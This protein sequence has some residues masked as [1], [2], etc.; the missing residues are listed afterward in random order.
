MTIK[1]SSKR[2]TIKGSS[3][4]P[5]KT[6]FPLLVFI[7]LFVVLVLAVKGGEILTG[8]NKT[9]NGNLSG[10]GSLTVPGD[11]AYAITADAS[12]NIYVG[13][14]GAGLTNNSIGGL[15]DWWL[16]K[17]YRNGTEDLTN[18]NKI[19][20]GWFNDSA[21]GQYLYGLDTDSSGNIYLIGSI[22]DYNASYVWLVNR[23]NSSGS[24]NRTWDIRS[25]YFSFGRDIAVDSNNNV[26]A[27]GATGTYTQHIEKY[28]TNAVKTW[29][30]NASCPSPLN[31]P[32]DLNAIAIDSTN[33]IFAAGYCGGKVSVDFFWDIQKFSNAGVQ[34][35]SWNVS[36]DPEDV[37]CES[38]FTNQC[39]SAVV[40]DLAIDSAGN[41][42]AVGYGQA[43][44]NATANYTNG[45]LGSSDDWLVR[46]YNTAG[47]L[48]WSRNFSSTLQPDSDIIYTVSID[49]SNNIYLAG[50]WN[51]SYWHVKKLDS[52]GVED[53]SWNKTVPNFAGTARASL[54]NNSMLFVAGDGL[55][56]NG[57]TAGD[58]W[59]Q[60]YL[61]ST[62]AENQSWNK[63]FTGNVTG[64]ATAL[65]FGVDTAYAL[66]A[67]TSGNIFVG[68]HGGG[69]VSTQTTNPDWWIKK[70]TSSGTED[71]TNWDI[72]LDGGLNY[73]DYL[74]AMDMDSNNNLYAVGEWIN[75]STTSDTTSRWHLQRF[76][77]SGNQNNTWNI[78]YNA[79]NITH[80]SSARDVVVDSN[81]NVWVFG[82]VIGSNTTKGND[83][84]YYDWHLE[85]YNTNALKTFDYNFSLDVTSNDQGYAIGVDSSN[86]IFI[87]GNV[88]NLFNDTNTEDWHIKKLSNAGVENMS[89]N[90]SYNSGYGHYD[91]INDLA[92]DSAGNVIVVGYGSALVNTTFDYYNTIS[93]SGADWLVRKYNTAGVLSWS[94]N[95]SYNT[96]SYDDVAY[97][98]AVDNNGSIYVGGTWVNSSG[99]NWHI[100]RLLSNGVVDT[101][102]DKTIPNADNSADLYAL[103]LNE[104]SL[105]AVG[106]ANNLNGSSNFDWQIKKY[107]TSAVA[108]SVDIP[109]WSDYATLLILIG[110]VGGF[111][112]VRRKEKLT[113]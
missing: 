112:I 24:W 60:S 6:V 51:V 58:W 109:E 4:T 53:A 93:G 45:V 85:K 11:V 91:K 27:V 76:N 66:T 49:N 17:F 105:Y 63:N 48:L 74:Y 29:E 50:V 41:V 95:A 46:K 21:V 75:G 86:N 43:L 59:I 89:W 64:Y 52:N 98:I 92:V 62:S 19:L 110:V 87:A 94:Y 61:T 68:G 99:T 83:P 3:K 57:S 96:Q 81:N 97:T 23:F 107:N 15:T 20:G 44:V 16:K 54:L 108:S 56:L 25:P 80:L 65:S 22:Y 78:T 111:L 100:K 102:W 1:G 33:N 10:Y 34:N 2:M 47:T 113:D 73:S 13:G 38:G 36:Y 12:G 8:W 69:L 77:T 84:S 9:A 18:W 71:K 5:L 101:D 90:I 106:D 82:Y 104:T 42:I 30:W 14:F 7:A 88:V 31:Y 28:N 39:L 40:N 79:N 70:Y 67:D 55:D 26:W 72:T 35:M 32:N 37:N 103:L